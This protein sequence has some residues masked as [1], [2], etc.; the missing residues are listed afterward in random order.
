MVR[1]GW[2]VWGE[3]GCVEVGYQRERRLLYG[4]FISIRTSTT[5]TCVSPISTRMCT[6]M[7]DRH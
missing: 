6:T 4:R 5:C 3:G 1:V 7:Q 2:C